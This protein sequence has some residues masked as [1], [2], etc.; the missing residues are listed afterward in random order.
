M[1][2]AGWVSGLDVQSFGVFFGIVAGILTVG[3]LGEYQVLK[4]A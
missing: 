2:F 4:N 3:N 1:G